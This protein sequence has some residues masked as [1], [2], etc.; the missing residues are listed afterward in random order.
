MDPR[1]RSLLAD[2]AGV[3]ARRQLLAVGL[4]DHDIAR[5]GRRRELVAVHRG[6][7]VDHTGPLPWV[8][9]AWAGVLFAW[10]AALCHDSALCTA[11]GSDVADVTDPLVHVA[12]AG[13]RRVREPAGVRIRRMIDF[14]RRVLWNLGPP[15]I[16]YEEAVVD[17][18]SAARSNLA[19]LGVLSRAVQQR[20]TTAARLLETVS[21]R[22]RVARRAWLVSVLSD[23]AEG[24]CSV[25]E[26]GYL[27]RVERAHGLARARRQVASLTR[28]GGTYRDVEYDGGLVVELDGR[29]FHDTTEQRDR[30][31]DRDLVTAVRGGAS[32]RISWGQV[33]DR[34]CWTAGMVGRLLRARG[35]RGT[36]RPCASSCAALR[37]SL[38]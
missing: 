30:D 4:V 13:S 28:G 33:F 19:A 3:V 10:P 34:P 17:V 21:A 37:V 23:V 26:Q 38:A 14:E 36:L 27:V 1:A 22:D 7:Y 12:I 16:R 6:V 11:G 35:W 2:Q 5:L 20:R 18:A 25:L 29:L 32:V 9:R 8:Q 31:F 15:R 24:A